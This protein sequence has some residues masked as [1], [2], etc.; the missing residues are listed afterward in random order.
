MILKGNQRAGAR[1]LAAHLMNTKDNEHIELHDV[2]GFMSVDLKGALQEIHA[3]SRATR[4][5]KYMFSLSLNPPI[6][7]NVPIDTFEKS[8]E[9]IERSLGL[10]KQPRVIV[11]HEKQGR[12]HAHCVWSRMLPVLRTGEAIIT[13]EAATLPIRCRIIL[14]DKLPNSRDPEVAS[15]WSNK[16]RSQ[17]F[18][19]NIY[20]Q[21]SASWRSQST[22]RPKNAEL[23]IERAEINKDE[24]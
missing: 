16:R 23:K 14:P 20:N 9:K 8:I 4:C 11:F 2:R 10:E 5:T 22:T 21:I 19:D 17:D 12:R 3:V 13:G 7:E 24:V 15:Q 18:T 1:E 6:E